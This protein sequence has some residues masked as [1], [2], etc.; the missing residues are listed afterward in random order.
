ML[1]LEKKNTKNELPPRI[2]EERPDLD[3]GIVYYKLIPCLC[4]YENEYIA[5]WFDWNTEEPTWLSIN[6][7]NTFGYYDRIKEYYILPDLQ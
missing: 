2:V 5:L 3:E 7:C 6:Y 4:I 1:N